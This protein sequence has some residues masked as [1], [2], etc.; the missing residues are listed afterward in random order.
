MSGEFVA[1]GYYLVKYALF[2]IKVIFL[3]KECYLYVL[4]E[5]YLSSGVRLVLSCKYPHQRGLAGSVRSNK[6]YLV[7]FVDVEADFFKKDFRSVTL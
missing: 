3:L 4:Q 7:A 5:H 2:R 6:S 1:G